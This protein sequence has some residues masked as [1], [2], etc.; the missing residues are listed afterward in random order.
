MEP[1]DTVHRRHLQ[2]QREWETWRREVWDVF[3]RA[4][5]I[6]DLARTIVLTMLFASVVLNVAQYATIDA[7][8]A[9]LDEIH[10]TAAMQGGW[11][12]LESAD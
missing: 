11:V 2:L 7:Q 1:R 8:S 10:Q 6:E 3:L 5:K 12:Y 9:K 4:P